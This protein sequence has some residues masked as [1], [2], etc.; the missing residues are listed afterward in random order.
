[1][2]PRTIA[3]A[4]LPSP[5]FLKAVNRLNIEQPGHAKQEIGKAKK[6]KMK[7]FLILMAM[8]LFM[9]VFLIYRL[10]LKLYCKPFPVF[11]HL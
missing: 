1:M 7:Y 5:L 8:Q 10:I 3:A 6:M 9:I 11:R 2:I 4:H